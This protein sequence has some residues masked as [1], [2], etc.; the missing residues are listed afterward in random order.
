MEVE[1][2]EDNTSIDWSKDSGL[3]LLALGVSGGK[4]ERH[5]EIQ[6]CYL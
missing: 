3:G 1:A 2:E 5:K 6:T 4:G